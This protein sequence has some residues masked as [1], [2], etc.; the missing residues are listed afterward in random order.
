MRHTGIYTEPFQW[1]LKEIWGISTVPFYWF[2]IWDFDLLL[3]LSEEK[4][5]MRSGLNQGKTPPL[6]KYL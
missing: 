6:P 1:G 4:A 3:L 5:G 2:G